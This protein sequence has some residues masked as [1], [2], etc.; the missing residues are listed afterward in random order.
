MA[1]DPVLQCT[2]NSFNRRCAI[3]GNPSYMYVIGFIAPSS[4]IH[5]MSRKIRVVFKAY[6]FSDEVDS[7]KDVN[8]KN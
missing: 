7:S 3:M 6:L 5:V 1:A 8:K 2:Y 4:F